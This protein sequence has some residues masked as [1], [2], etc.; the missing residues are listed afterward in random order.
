[1]HSVSIKCC[2]IPM[3]D[4]W[5]W[6]IEVFWKWL[7]G[8]K[9]PLWFIKL[10]PRLPS[11]QVT[12]Y[13]TTAE[14]TSSTKP[15]PSVVPKIASAITILVMITEPVN[16]IYTHTY[17]CE[18]TS[19]STVKTGIQIPKTQGCSNVKHRNIMIQDSFHSTQ[20]YVLHDVPAK[21]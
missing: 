16:Y 7:Q 19:L 6:Y 2:I 18:W 12:P 17:M 21:W 5:M 20:L 8:T 14:S 4:I 11:F 3:Q 10:Y 13:I 9:I 15:S 1:M